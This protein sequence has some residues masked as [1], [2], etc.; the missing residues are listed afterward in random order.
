MRALIIIFAVNLFLPAPAFA[1]P[2]S[3]PVGAVHNIVALMS[4]ADDECTA[5]LERIDEA[6]DPKRRLI[7]EEEA[8]FFC[9]FE[10][11]NVLRLTTEMRRW[12]YGIP[13]IIARG[14]EKAARVYVEAMITYGECLALSPDVVKYHR[15]ECIDAAKDHFKEGFKIYETFADEIIKKYLSMAAKKKPSTPVPASQPASTPAASQPAS[16]PT[17]QS[18]RVRWDVKNGR[19]KPGNCICK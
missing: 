4:D 2:A 17:S 12:L 18:A 5:A 14:Y 11:E 6:A 10:Y 1:E 13:L 7:V 3:Q 16:G 9:R 15:E 8:V 19:Q